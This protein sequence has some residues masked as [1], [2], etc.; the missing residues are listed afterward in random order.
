MDDQRIAAMH[1]KI[2]LIIYNKYAHICKFYP[3]P[4]C[5]S[6]FLYI[7]GVFT[8]TYVHTCILCEKYLIYCVEKEKGTRGFSEYGHCSC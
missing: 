3:P 1:L 6:L 2:F 8:Y 7:C 4:D 5:L